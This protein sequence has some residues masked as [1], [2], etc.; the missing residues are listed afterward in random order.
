MDTM[1]DREINRLIDESVANGRLACPPD[2]RMGRGMMRRAASGGLVSP[3]PGL[4][5]CTEEWG[6]RDPIE[7]HLLLVRTLA[8]M[9]P[10]WIFCGPTAALLHGLYVSFIDLDLVHVVGGNTK[11]SRSVLRHHRRNVRSERVAGVH[12]TSLD[13]TVLD[14]IREMPFRRALGIAD[15]YLMVTGSTPDEAI[16]RITR[17]HHGKRGVRRAKEII[18]DADPLSEN[19]GES[20][21]RAVMIE[22]G[23]MM[24]RLQVP[25][26]VRGRSE[27][28]RVDFLWE[29]R[30]GNRIVYVAGELDGL[31]KMRDERML[32]GRTLEQFER[33]ERNRES[34]LTSLG[35]QVVRFTFDDCMRTAP[36]LEKLRRFRIPR[37]NG[38]PL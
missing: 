2:D 14:A 13:Q 5:A 16:H 17:A 23:I 12:A 34:D 30:V 31:I 35:L 38:Q 11:A 37:A 15:S 18:L 3:H 20:Y 8:D 7:R 32:A 26:R 25:F 6:K 21:A 22:E 1:L 4:Y 19:G 33:D 36:L 24:P 29:I 10:D 9:H 27:P 28:Y